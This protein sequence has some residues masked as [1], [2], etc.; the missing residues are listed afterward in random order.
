MTAPPI[1]RVILYVKE[2][3]SVAS[4]YQR[5]FSMTPVPGATETWLEL[6]SPSGGCSIAFHRAAKSQKSGAAIKLV[7]AV[8]D[9]EAFVEAKRREGLQF[10]PI[11]RPAGFQFA[12][13]KDPAG[14]S[15]SISSR[16][17]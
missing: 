16:G 17:L 13:T 3:P 5:F 2:I 12:N 6:V 1:A 15:I 9:V 14:N 10:G 4:F 11:H 8:T 7:F